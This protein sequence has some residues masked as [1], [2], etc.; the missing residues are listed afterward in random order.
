MALPCDAPLVVEVEST[1]NSFGWMFDRLA[2][3]RYRMRA[4]RRQSS[5]TPEQQLEVARVWWAGNITMTELA[6]VYGVGIYVVSRAI[7]QTRRQLIREDHDHGYH[8]Y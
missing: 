5:L 4:A 8:Y 3:H 1:D 6:R 2:L 7:A